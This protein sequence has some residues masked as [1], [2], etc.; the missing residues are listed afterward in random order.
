MGKV[1]RPT[2]T[3]LGRD[4]APKV[5]P[6]DM[7][8]SP[9]RLERFRR[10]AKAL[11]ALDHPAIVTVHSV[12][13]ADR[14]HFLTMQLVVGQPLDKLIPEGGMAVD[15]VVEI[16]AALADALAAAHEKGIVHRDLKPA[17]VMVTDNGRVKIL[18]F[19]LAKVAA[20][21]EGS[22]G[23]SELETAMK[24][25]EGIVMGT[26]PYMSPEQVSG[27]SVDHRTDIFSLGIMLY[28]MACGRRP[29]DG[30]SSAELISSILRDTPRRLRDLRADLPDALMRVIERCLEKS[31]A[32]RVPSA[33]AVREALGAVPNV[34]PTSVL[35][36]G[37]PRCRSGIQVPTPTSR[38][39]P[40]G[41]PRRS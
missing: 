21:G 15:R 25:R 9:E 41:C 27:R 1:Y 22:P 20:A 12:D 35:T 32:D 38:R 29:F 17:N 7:A 4:V 39:W 5:L 8:G 19:G 2:D 24:T 14:V 34:R 36:E 6:A 33:R 26:V 40:R 11:A 3:K 37:S 30:R 16:G 31:T 10:E 18:D 13:E 23:D 28:E